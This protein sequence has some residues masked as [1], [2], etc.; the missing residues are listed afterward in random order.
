MSFSV[1]ALDHAP[2]LFSAHGPDGLLQLA[3]SGLARVVADDMP[4]RFLGK[5]DLLR[6]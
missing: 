2:R 6:A 5:L 3:H 4:H 1:L